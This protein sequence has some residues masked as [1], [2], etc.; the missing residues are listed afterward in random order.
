LLGIGEPGDLFGAVE[1]GCDLFDCVAPTRMGRTGALYTHGG[2]M[3]IYNA[4][5][6]RDLSPVDEKCECYTCKNYTRSY[7]AHLYRSNEMLASTLGSIHNLTF[8][9]KMVDNMREAI[10]NG[11]FEKYRDE[12]LTNYYGK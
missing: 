10:L 2:R 4:Q 8:I 5:Y 1:N 11:T 12:F 7:L 6:V 3:N 9:I